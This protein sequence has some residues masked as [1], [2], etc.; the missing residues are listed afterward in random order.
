MRAGV[1]GREKAGR[2]GLT[3]VRSQQYTNVV[4]PSDGQS[5]GTWKYDHKVLIKQSKMPAMQNR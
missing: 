2:R 5:E 4:V 1:P 3:W